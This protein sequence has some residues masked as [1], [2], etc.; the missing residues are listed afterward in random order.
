METKYHIADKWDLK[1]NTLYGAHTDRKNRVNSEAAQ[2][3]DAG[4]A[5]GSFSRVTAAPPGSVSPQLSRRRRLTVGRL[6]GPGWLPL[7][8]VTVPGDDNRLFHHVDAVTL[9]QVLKQVKDLLCSGTLEGKNPC[10]VTKRR[11]RKARK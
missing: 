10:T 1:I 2:G 6:G 9:H 11:V 4:A 7:R 3:R 8:G 5:K